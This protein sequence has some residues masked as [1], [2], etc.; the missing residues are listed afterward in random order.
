MSRQ[1]LPESS[2]ARRE[3]YENLVR[4]EHVEQVRRRGGRRG[5]PRLARR[6]ARALRD[7]LITGH[8][9]HRGFPGLGLGGRRAAMPE[10]RKRRPTTS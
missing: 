6:V 7:R 4:P 1:R 3:S 5:R 9:L 8:G 10:H 2:E